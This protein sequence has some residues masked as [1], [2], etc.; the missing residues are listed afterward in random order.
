MDADLLLSSGIDQLYT[1]RLEGQK[2]LRRV[3]DMYLTVAADSESKSPLVPRAKFGLARTH[4]ALGELQAVR[5]DYDAIVKE[6][7][8]FAD[9]ARQR[10]TDLDRGETKA[11]YDWFAKYE[12]PRPSDKPE[13]KF[14]FLNES[15]DRASGVRLP[16]NVGGKPAGP[17]TESTPQKAEGAAAPSGEAPTNSGSPASGE[18]PA[19]G[20]TEKTTP[21][22]EGAA[23]A[24]P[25]TEGV[26]PSGSTTESAPPAKETTAPPANDSPAP[27]PA[28]EK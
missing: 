11:F 17:A 25:S 1:D 16:S 15:L 7:G 20:S 9:A 13:P 3:A 26:A 6:G 24:S 22:V 10:A 8:P 27:P 28:A 4:E 19:S 2:Q 5:V 23:P 18:A 21:A 14:D 12:P